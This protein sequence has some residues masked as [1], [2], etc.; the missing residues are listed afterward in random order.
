MPANTNKRAAKAKRTPLQESTPKLSVTRKT[1]PKVKGLAYE[2]RPVHNPD[3][4]VKQLPNNES[5]YLHRNGRTAP[6]SEREEWAREQYRLNQPLDRILIGTGWTPENL[7]RCLG[8]SRDGN[9][10]MYEYLKEV[11]RKHETI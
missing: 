8:L 1:D 4:K 6:L 3:P 9:A 10:K 7:M 2:T 11:K 5:D